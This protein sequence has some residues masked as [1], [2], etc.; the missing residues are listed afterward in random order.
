MPSRSLQ[1]RRLQDSICIDALQAHPRNA[2]VEQHRLQTTQRNQK[3]V[4][5]IAS[6]FQSVGSVETSE[7]QLHTLAHGPHYFIT[8]PDILLQSAQ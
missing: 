3:I 2:H 1:G 8:R 7:D 4:L 6:C 5:I